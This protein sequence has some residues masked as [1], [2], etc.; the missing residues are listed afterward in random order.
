MTKNINVFIFFLCFSFFGFAQNNFSGKVVNIE[1]GFELEN[2]QII[3]LKTKDTIFSNE[4]G[5]FKV[6]VLG[7][8]TFQ[9]LGFVDKEIN[10]SDASFR[11]VQLEN[12]AFV[13][14]EIVINSNHLPR[15]LKKATTTI[16]VI[17]TK[18]IERSNNTDFAPILNRVPGIFMQSGSLNTNRI[19]IRG[20]GSRNLFGTSKI[21]AYF[22]DIPLTNG[23]GETT[24][25]DFELASIASF[26]I[27]KGATS[28]SYGAGLGGTILLKE[29]S[30]YFQ[31]SNIATEFSIGDFGLVKG[32]VN[33]N[34]GFKN[35]SVRAVF[36]DTKS[37]GFRKNNEYNRQT[38]TINSNHYINQKNELTVLAS[39]VDL[40]AFIPSSINE[41]DF[42]NNPA[43]AAFT[44][45]QSKG[46]ED[47]NRGVLG[48]TWTYKINDN[49]E[50]VTS[51]FTSFRDAL[52]P[53]P[54]N[55]L[56]ENS[57]AVG[58][59]SRVV[60]TKKVFNKNMNFTFGGEVFKDTYKVKT[61]ENLYQNFPEGNGSVSGE[62]LSN[63]KEN[64][65]YYNLF[66]ESDYEISSKTTFS[67]GLNLNQTSYDLEDN[68]MVSQ[69]N[70]DQSGDFKFNAILSPK[71]GLSYVISD[72]MSVFSSISH[73]F[74]PISL[75]ETL[76]PD[77]QINID[78]KPET[79]WNFEMG[80]RGSFLQ[81]KLNYAISLYRLHIKNLVVSR[82]TAQ[83]EFIGINA[84]ATKHDG[85][86]MSLD[87]SIF[88]N[89]TVSIHPFLS[90]TL[91]NF[92]FEE[93]I[94]GEN[95]FSGNELTGVPKQILN[96]GFDVTSKV[97]FYGNINYQFVDKMPIT[98]SNSLYSDAYNI[99]NFKVGY[100][101]NI[102]TDLN[103]NL[104]FGLNNIFDE[105]YAS[106]ILINA[107]GFGGVAPRYYYPGNP[108]NYF[109][110]VRLNYNL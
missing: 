95:N 17:N 76:L 11:I 35:N 92:K 108:I 88:K 22:K 57:F 82:R 36:S 12:S 107:T 28:S 87:F 109:S 48:V 93:F 73:G 45:Q 102:N 26:E 18:D 50:Q 91:N 10:I 65:T 104:F 47:A 81:N 44:W 7:I 101:K 40:K 63:F 79:G 84:G 3:N 75:A 21:R 70:P 24:I 99:T 69:N 9:K 61:F 6:D 38:F 80:S 46:F 110:G 106:Q 67:V 52:E 83:D 77:G 51:V 39:Y 74:S 42:R 78:L 71:V 98:D 59:R 94:D 49:L 55:V 72:N 13:L 96:V 5:F 66:L 29:Q 58:A 62:E 23:S 19:T 100:S 4:K 15:K 89:K 1:N 97:G 41:D 14:N 68:F 16:Q 56:Q 86:E 90:Y 30:S 27:E 37:D 2:V 33:L 85:L 54:F 105:K 34:L 31:D 53:R 43:K 20:I 8:Y 25:E 32:I 64:R 103:F 60:G